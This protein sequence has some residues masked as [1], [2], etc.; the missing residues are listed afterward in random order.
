VLKP[1]KQC[2][3][4]EKRPCRLSHWFP[5]TPPAPHWMDPGITSH[6][7]ISGIRTG[8]PVSNSHKISTQFPA[9]LESLGSFWCSLGTG[10]PILLIFLHVQPRSAGV[11]GESCFWPA[12]PVFAHLLS[13]TGG[14]CRSGLGLMNVFCSF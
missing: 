11:E 13:G 14:G 4:L 9:Y 7:E 8:T 10:T 1:Q 12:C 2:I 6:L 5:W 3:E